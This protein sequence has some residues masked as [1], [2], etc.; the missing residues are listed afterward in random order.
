MDLFTTSLSVATSKG[1]EVLNLEKKTPWSVPNLKQAHTTS[2]AARLN[3]V[4]P[5]AMFRLSDGEFLCVYEECAVYIDKHGEVS[6]GVVLE[7]VGKA[8][9]AALESGFLILFDTDF[10]EIRDA[11]LGRLKQIIP[12]KDVRCLDNGRNGGLV[13]RSIKFAL[14]HPEQERSQIVMELVLNEGLRM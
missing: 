2:I 13:G 4:D 7:F 11:H 10:V 14:Q 5:L 9:A 12:G 8:K 1:F 6:R 3:G